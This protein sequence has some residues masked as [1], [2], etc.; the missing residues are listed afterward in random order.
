MAYTRK[1]E[2]RTP[3]EDTEKELSNLETDI[4]QIKEEGGEIIQM[5]DFNIKIVQVS[6]R[7]SM[8]LNKVVEDCNLVV[9]NKTDKCQGTWT[10]VN[11][12]NEKEKSA[13]DYLIRTNET[14]NNVKDMIIDGGCYKVKGK[15]DTIILNTEVPIKLKEKNKKETTVEHNCKYRLAKVQRNTKREARDNHS[16]DEKNRDYYSYTIKSI[17]NVAFDTIGKITRKYYN[18]K[19]VEC[20]ELQ[21]ARKE[22][23]KENT[24]V[25]WMKSRNKPT[26]HP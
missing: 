22:K 9:L 4:L 14:Y 2:S 5:G 19:K 24:V 26:K 21:E 10:R 16:K 12:K 6:S 13:I 18:N 1:Q 23:Q 7:D 25:P 20:A 8:L 17:E 3:K 11:T 15:N